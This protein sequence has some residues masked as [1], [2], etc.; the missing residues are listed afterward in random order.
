MYGILNAFVTCNVPP[1]LEAA[2][3]YHHFCAMYKEG[4][5][6]RYPPITNEEKVT[7]IMAQTSL[8]PFTGE[9]LAP[10]VYKNGQI[11]ILIYLVEAID[12]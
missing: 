9:F 7:H 8:T 1:D 2:V 12:L 10:V 3:Y 11:T 6:G 4:L 5:I